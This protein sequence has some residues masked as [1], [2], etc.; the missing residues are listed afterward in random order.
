MCIIPTNANANANTFELVSLVIVKIMA[1]TIQKKQFDDDTY[2]EMA[3]CILWE[4]YWLKLSWCDYD[5][6]IGYGSDIS[7]EKCNGDRNG[8][9]RC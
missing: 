1:I 2:K 7:R 3:M 9:I 6:G 8:K 5:N 4:R